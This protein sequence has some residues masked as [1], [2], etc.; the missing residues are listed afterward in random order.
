MVAEL[1]NMFVRSPSLAAGW[2]LLVGLLLQLGFLVGGSAQRVYRDRKYSRLQEQQFAL[3]LRAARLRVEGVEQSKPAWNG[4]RKFTVADKVQECA[5]TFSFYLQPQDGRPL[6]AFRPGQFLTFQLKVPGVEKPV[7]RCYSLSDSA[8]PDYYRVSIKRCPPPRDSDHAPGVASS[9]FCD[10]VQPGDILDVKAPNGHFFLDLAKDRPVVLIA[11]GVGVTPMISMANALLAAESTREV[12]FFFG[13]R[14]SAD[15]MFKQAMAEFAARPNFHVHVCYSKPLPTERIGHDYQHEGRVTVDLFKSLLPSHNYDYFLCGPSPFME[16]ITSDL[17]A[18]GVPDAW[19][20]FEA[21]GPASVKRPVEAKGGAAVER[22]AVAEG[23][24]VTFARSART[25]SWTGAHASILDLAEE[26]GIPIAASCRSGNCGSCVV[27]V[28]SGEVE[29]VD[30]P[31]DKPESG[32]CLACVCK[33][34]GPV[35]LD[36]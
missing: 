3:E 33:P 32:T 26:H 18:W 13:A 29:F 8:R 14:N 25:I 35:V 4:I 24:E 7:V 11:G 20:H 16:S 12:W 1:L 19:V 36:A 10:A 30:R 6:P 23:V 31:G 34:N 27:G 17:R 15:H 21:F 22:V 5:D 28:K 2:F 9:F